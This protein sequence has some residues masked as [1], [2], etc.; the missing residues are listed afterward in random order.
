MSGA[1]IHQ[2]V[3]RWSEELL[4]GRRGLGPVAS[5]LDGQELADWS[6]LLRAG[7]FV[8]GMWTDGSGDAPAMGALQIGPGRET[9]VIVRVLP[10]RDANGRMSELIHV[11][12]GPAPVLTGRLAVGLW[13]WA[14]WVRPETAGALAP[15]MPPLPSGT[16][17]AEARDTHHALHEASLRH[18]LLP[19]PAADVLNAPAEHYQLLLPPRTGP[20]GDLAAHLTYGLLTVLGDFTGEEPWTFLIR[21]ELKSREADA[22]L[23]VVDRAP[24]PSAF[25]R[26]RRVPL[27]PDTG[28]ARNGPVSVST[29][30]SIIT[31]IADGRP[32]AYPRTALLSARDAADWADTQLLRLSGVA[33]LLRRAVAGSLTAKEERDL[34][35]PGAGLGR[36]LGTCSPA[37]TV[38]IL[39]LW[40]DFPDFPRTRDVLVASGVL[41]ALNAARHE[42]PETQS[43]M[44][45]VQAMSPPAGTVEN[46]LAG[47]Y[48]HGQKPDPNEVSRVL[49]AAATIGV[50]AQRDPTVGWLL[51]GLEPYVLVQWSIRLIRPEPVGD[52]RPRPEPDL[53]AACLQQIRMDRIDAARRRRCRQIFLEDHGMAET[54]EAIATDPARRTALYAKALRAAYEAPRHADD[55]AEILDDLQ[56]A[57]APLSGTVWHALYGMS[58]DPVICFAVA[59]GAV[60]RGHED[61]GETL[62][63]SLSME[64]IIDGIADPGTEPEV[65]RHA[66]GHLLH[67]MPDESGSGIAHARGGLLRNG[68]LAG[69]VSTAYPAPSEQTRVLRGL[70]GQA[71]GTDLRGDT[72]REIYHHAKTT[73]PSL[74]AAML[75]LAT[76]QGREEIVW[77]NTELLVRSAGVS[78]EE[79]YRNVPT[80]RPHRTN[81]THQ[82]HQTDDDTRRVS[83]HTRE[84][85][86]DTREAQPDIREI[87]PD[88]RGTAHDRTTHDRPDTRRTAHDH[89]AHDRT[90]HGRPA[91]ARSALPAPAGPPRARFPVP[92]PFFT[93]P[94]PDSTRS[95]D[96]G[97]ADTPTY[98]GRG[99]R[100]N[101]W[102]RVRAPRRAPDP[103]LLR[104][105]IKTAIAVL[106]PGRRSGGS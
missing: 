17:E 59:A 76:P 19:G 38:E 39:R 87:R 52:G 32:I 35:Q 61:I 3:F 65:T 97:G 55:V 30:A 106:M 56:R 86:P 82:T 46:S 105:G 25:A 95:G 98:T 67:R 73:T 14:G 96:S 53:A 89:T 4:V 78:W 36:E 12:L 84:I 60:R 58:A 20:G 22:R 2:I 28:Q 54:V 34:A 5:S 63:S 13:N 72:V 94:G 29:A 18:P 26:R 101:P 43:L 100:R 68:C 70:L 57:R 93:S 92:R 50:D 21:A 1:E 45:A 48:R 16:L 104:P 15:R 6:V 80:A 24:P 47:L 83:P 74:V 103:P 7:D 31:A 64:R 23:T 102:A 9:G 79:I 91:Q 62:L 8:Q 75:A 51:A 37:E 27:R 11:L 69:P 66:I 85:R 42:A 88:T 49:I 99:W 71:Y 40:R 33:D 10:V 90:A 41:R 44:H 81:Q 77:A